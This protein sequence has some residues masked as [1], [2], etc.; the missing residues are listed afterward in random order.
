MKIVFIGPS[1]PDA[2][3]Q[4]AAPDIAFRRPARQGDIAEATLRGANVIGLVDGIFEDN[5]AVW[6]KEIL[7]ALSEGVRLF[8]AASMGALRAA[9]CAAFG[10]VGVGEVFARYAAGELIDDDAVAQLHAPEEL[11]SAPLSEPLVNIEATTD[12]LLA[13]GMIDAIEASAIMAAGR[14]VFF[15][16]RTFA[17]VLAVASSLSAPRRG[18]LAGLLDRHRHDVKR[19]DALALIALVQAADDA[20]AR[21]PAE[22][23]FAETQIWVRLL[24]GIRLRVAATA[25]P[26]PRQS[27]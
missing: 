26:D 8:G 13:G 24:T 27:P 19:D 6:H 17:A 15:K 2:R 21:R 25:D 18:E 5:A 23:A 9:E 14:G 16:Q 3:Q 10:M 11:G 20:R 12:R 22:W 4:F 1:L 7:F